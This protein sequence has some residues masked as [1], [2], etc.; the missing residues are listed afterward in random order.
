MTNTILFGV[1]TNT[2]FPSVILF[3]LFCVCQQILCVI[4]GVPIV[5]MLIVFHL[6]TSMALILIGIP[7]ATVHY[8]VDGTSVSHWMPYLEDWIIYT[9]WFSFVA[10]EYIFIGSNKIY[11]HGPFHLRGSFHVI[12]I[13]HNKN[14]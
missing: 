12:N 5:A 8:I 7:F 14:N 4:V 10:A 9:E 13:N 6:F 3:R 1:Y 2:M 11:L